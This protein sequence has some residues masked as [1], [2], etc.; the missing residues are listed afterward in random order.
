MG[1]GRNINTSTI[2]N[3]AADD[4]RS[5]ITTAAPSTAAGLSPGSVLKIVTTTIASTDGVS[6]LAKP[7][8]K[9]T[10][11]SDNPYESTGQISD[12]SPDKRGNLN[13]DE[14]FGSGEQG[15][16]WDKFAFSEINDQY[17]AVAVGKNENSFGIYADLRKFKE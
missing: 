12:S 16:P 6:K 4:K 9:N 7:V 17:Y 15:D 13:N 10:I 1:A 11:R 3:S 14:D 8:A 2:I 5:T